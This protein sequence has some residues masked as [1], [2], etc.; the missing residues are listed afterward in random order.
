MSAAEVGDSWVFKRIGEELA[1]SNWSGVPPWD[2]MA[3]LADELGLPELGELADVVRLSG[4]SQGAEIYTILR[5]RASSMRDAIMSAELAK[6]NAI[7]QRMSM[8]VAALGIVFM[9]ILVT[10]GLLRVAGAG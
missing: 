7:G 9:V 1:L 10:P 5:A 3:E 2:S 4:G 6:A 8:P